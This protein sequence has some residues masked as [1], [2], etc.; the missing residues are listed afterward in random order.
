MK[1]FGLLGE[2]LSHSLSPVI[3]K[4]IYEHLN[5]DAAYSLY[6]FPAESLVP[7]VQGI[8]ALGIDGVNVTIPY[9]VKVMECLDAL[10][11]EAVRI[12]AV[13]TIHNSSGRLIGYNTD[14]FGFGR[15]LDKHGILTQDK[16]AVILG[17]GGAAKA[18]V[19]YLEDHGIT[20]IKIMARTPVE[21]ATFDAKRYSILPYSEM[22]SLR[23][24]YLLVNCTPV[25]MYPDTAASP[26]E[27]KQLNKFSYVVDLVYNPQETLLLKQ[28]KAQGVPAYNGLFMLVAQAAAA[29]EI[30]AQTTI[31]EDILDSIHQKLCAVI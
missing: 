26:I 25:G 22:T 18:V 12:G 19:A 8:R 11:D 7:A 4:S 5:I 31:S 14:Y 20:D 16:S 23:Q 6:Q 30:W 17:S 24:T 29:V 13:N 27:A 10:S 1:V 2:K 28:A 9:K 15:M 21:V 3:H